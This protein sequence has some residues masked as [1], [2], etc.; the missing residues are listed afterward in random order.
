MLYS[1]VKHILCCVFVLFVFVLCL[2]YSGVKHILCCVF[3]LFV[4]VLCLVYSGVK[5]ILCCVFLCCFSL[6]YVHYVA[7]FSG[8]STFDCPFDIL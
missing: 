7:S 4:F 1:G 5:H 2:V 6:S 8:L 3:V